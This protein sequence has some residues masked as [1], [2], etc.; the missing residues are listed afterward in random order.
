MVPVAA[1]D[2]RSS[3]QLWRYAA[4]ISNSCGSPDIIVFRVCFT[5]LS[6]CQKGPESAF[7]LGIQNGFLGFEIFAF[8]L[9]VN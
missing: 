2:T 8:V 9:E 3:D 6:D 1:G 5:G 4:A 7:G